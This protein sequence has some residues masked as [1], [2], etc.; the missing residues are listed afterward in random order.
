[1]LPKGSSVR[2]R[3]LDQLTGLKVAYQGE[4]TSDDIMT[5]LAEKGLKFTAFEYDK[6]INCFDELRNG[7]VDIIVCDSVVAYFYAAQP[8][9]PFEIVWEGSGE[10]LGICIK[11]GNTALTTAVEAAMAALFADG[12]IQ[13]ISQ[14]VFGRD[15]VSGVKR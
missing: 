12:T 6:V 2:A 5:D 7:R 13:K 9:A 8:G 11:K 4:T 14:S 1:V 15:L 10:E 3:N